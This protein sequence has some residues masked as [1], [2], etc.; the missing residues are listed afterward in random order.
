M[1]DQSRDDPLRTDLHALHILRCV[2]RTSSF[3]V[4]ADD[5]GMSQSSVSYAIDRLRVVFN[6]PLFVR[7]GRGISPTDR[8]TQVVEGIEVMLQKFQDLAVPQRFDPS[9]ATDRFVLSCNFYERSI[10]LPGIMERV[11]REAPNIRVSVIQANSE[12]HRQLSEGICDVVVAPLMARQSGLYSQRLLTERYAC[13]VSHRNPLAQKGITLDDYARARHLLV[14]PAF[15]WRPYFHEELD[16]LGLSI[17][18][19]LEVPS[20]GEIDRILTNTDLVLTATSG[21]ARVFTPRIAC[22]PAPFA[23]MFPVEMAWAG[24]THTAGA[25]QWFRQII[26]DTARSLPPGGVEP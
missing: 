21:L 26:A 11:A 2:H 4:A 23:C 13:F 7:M 19:V 25:H 24:R 16:R 3:R 9:T 12:G 8:C 20:F 17:N 22:V 14:K 1:N 15:G 6:D 18:P 5:L 10:L